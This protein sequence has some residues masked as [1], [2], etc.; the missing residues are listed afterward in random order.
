MRAVPLKVPDAFQPGGRGPGLQRWLVDSDLSFGNSEAGFAPP[1]GSIEGVQVP[2]GWVVF[3]GLQAIQIVQEEVHSYW[4]L[5]L[6]LTSTL[7]NVWVIEDSVWLASLKR[8][9]MQGQQHFLVTLYDELIEVICNELLFGSGVFN[10]EK[11]IES[12][13]QLAFAYL[14]RAMSREAQGNSDEARADYERYI[15]ISPDTASVEYAR[16]C[17][18]SLART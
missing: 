16:R 7:S 9:H 10:L 5:P 13:P 17:L 8:R 12:F 3:H 1:N 4:H 11:A 6:D 18:R 14:R 2:G 15:S